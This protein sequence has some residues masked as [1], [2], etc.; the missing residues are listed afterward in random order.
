MKSALEF[1]FPQVMRANEKF[2]VIN[3]LLKMK[4]LTISWSVITM[5]GRQIRHAASTKR[6]TQIKQKPN[7]VGVKPTFFL[8][9]FDT[10]VDTPIKE[11]LNIYI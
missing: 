4:A 8:I 10:M 7:A 1:F 3:K 6:G 5:V 2:T 11:M 9:S